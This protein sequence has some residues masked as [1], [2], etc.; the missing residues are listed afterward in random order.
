MKVVHLRAEPVCFRAILSCEIDKA[1]NAHFEATVSGYVAES[2]EEIIKLLEKAEGFVL[3][4]EE[5][6]EEASIFRGI[7]CKAKIKTE[8]DQRILT[9]VAKSRAYSLD[10]KR[11]TCSFQNPD[12]TY[13]DIV[14]QIIGKT[15]DTSVIFFAGMEK[16]NEFILQY[17]ETDWE[18]LKRLAARLGTVLVADCT[19]D[20]IC[21]YFG[22]PRKKEVEDGSSENA[23]LSVSYICSD[24]ERNKVEYQLV[25]RAVWKLCSPMSIRGRRVFVYSIHGRLVGGEMVWQYRLRPSA[26]FECAAPY[27]QEIIGASLPGYVLEA[28]ETL[29]KLELACESGGRENNGIWF[30]FA[31]VYASPD[32]GGWYFMPERNS[33]VRLCFPDEKERNAYAASCVFLEDQPGRRNKPEV[34]FIRTMEGK[35]LRFTPESIVITNN[36]GMEICLDDGNGIRIKSTGNIELQSKDGMALSSG[37]RLKVDSNG[38]ILLKQDENSVIVKEGV[39]IDGLRVQFR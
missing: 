13:C 38:G 14:K 31:T 16:A 21:F 7:I 19:N 18:F 30:P 12:D 5:N 1:V 32:G 37:E 8:G 4:G 36:K 28:K 26:D 24:P 9:I 29:V 39:R 25:S 2:A 34:K 22:L 6:G 15:K 20:R 17:Q 23:E 10:L 11:N 27:N 33:M 35:E 3:Y